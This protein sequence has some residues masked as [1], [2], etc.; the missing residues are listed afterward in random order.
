MI[1][2]TKL[3]KIRLKKGVSQTTV[4]KETGLPRSVINKTESGTNDNPALSTVKKLADYY[5]ITIDSLL[6]K[7]A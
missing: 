2:T 7:D 6:V 5:G 4:S 1:D 3:L